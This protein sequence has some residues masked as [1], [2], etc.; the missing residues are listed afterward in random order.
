MTYASLHSSS[1]NKINLLN[2]NRVQLE[3]FLL[4]LGE[5]A[6]R[7]HQI[8]KWMYHYFCND[9]NKMTNL[10]KELQFKLNKLAYISYPT[11]LNQQCSVDGTIKWK[12]LVSHSKLIETIYIPE[13]NRATLCISSQVGCMLNCQ[14]CSTGKMGFK[15]NLSVSDIIG[16]LWYVSKIIYLNKFKYYSK[17]TNIVFMGMGEPLLNFNNV[18]NAL[19]IMLDRHGF[20]MSKHHITLSTAGIVPALYKL[21]HTIDISLALSLHA[22]NDI[23]RNKLMPINKKYNIQSLLNATKYYLQSSTSNRGYVTIEYVMLSNVNDSIQCAKE[24]VQLLINIPS[25]VNLIPWNCITGSSYICSNSATI[26]IFSKY[27]IKHGLFTTIRKNRGVD[28][29]GACGQLIVKKQ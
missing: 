6:F 24:L 20:Q 17:I 1:T 14:F 5:K 11:F 16:Q 21:S 13:K 27:L 8:M 25:K 29:L 3:Q 4:K 15:G 7:A 18:I 10:N 28:I 9:F 22:P 26:N 19:Q 12:V 2:L 23:L